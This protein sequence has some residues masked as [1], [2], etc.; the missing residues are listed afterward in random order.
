MSDILNNLVGDD[1]ETALELR[2]KLVM[3]Y[4]MVLDAHVNELISFTKLMD[5]NQF[6]MPLFDLLDPEYIWQTNENEAWKR[7]G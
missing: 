5:I 3:W 6:I 1:A 2:N 7:G 4:E